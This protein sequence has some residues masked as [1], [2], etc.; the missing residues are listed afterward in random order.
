MNINRENRDELNAVLTVK[1]EKPDYEE[2]VDKILGDY[3]KKAQLNGFRP[4]KVPLGIIRKMYYKPVLMEEIHKVLSETIA[5]Y[6]RDENLYIIG[7]PLVHEDDNLP[8]IDWDK[9]T[10]F[11]FS[12]DIGLAPEVDVVPA[13]GDNIPYYNIEVGDKARDEYIEQIK[14]RFGSFKEVEVITGTELIKADFEEVDE[15]GNIADGG[16]KAQAK[17]VNFEFMQDEETKNRFRGLK[18][19]D[20]LV[21]DVKKAFN[22]ETDLAAMLNIKKEELDTV[23]NNFKVTVGNISVF[24]KAEIGQDVYDSMYGKDQVKTD[25][26]FLS[27]ITEEIKSSYARESSYRFRIDAKDFYM[28]KFISSLPDE[29]YKRWILQVNEDKLTR[30]QLDKDYDNY[31]RDLKWQLIRNKFVRELQVEV[32]ETELKS[33]VT[34]M[35]KAQFMQYYG[36]PNMPDNMVSKYVDEA[37]NN[38]GERRRFQDMLIEEKMLDMVQTI[39]KPTP[40]DITWDDFKELYEKKEEQL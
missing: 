6:F 31:A 39:V 35:Y 10:E 13:E 2:R 16:I 38:E 29:F 25:D 18:V 32:S 4:G 17:S 37:L 22:N 3:R 7:E 27:K 19:G 12:F 1:I 30:E 20:S 15:A 8:D 33:F 28:D 40:K 34:N 26:E 21:V 24:Q 9:D 36:I 23:K 5:K 14:T 11:D